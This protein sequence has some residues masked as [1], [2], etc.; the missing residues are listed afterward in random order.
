MLNSEWINIED[1]KNIPLYP[2]KLRDMI[3]LLIKTETPLYLG[4]EHIF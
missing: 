4:S 3:N 1:V 2:Q